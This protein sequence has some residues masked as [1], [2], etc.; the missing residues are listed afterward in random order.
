MNDDQMTTSTGD[1]KFQTVLEKNTFHY[2]N[3][4]F[5]NKF[6]T[7][8]EKKI[9][10]IIELQEK[11]KEDVCIK[12]LIDDFLKKDNG[13]DLLLAINGIS[14]ETLLRIVTIIRV[15]NDENINKFFNKNKWSTGDYDKE[16]PSSK[17]KKLIKTNKYFRED[18]VKFFLEVYNEP[19]REKILPKFEFEKL[20]PSKISNI[21]TLTRDTIDTLIRSKVKGNYSAQFENNAEKLIK[22]ILEELN[23]PYQKGDLPLLSEHDSTRKRTMDF[24]IPNKKNPKIVIESSYVQTTSSGLGDKAKTE[25]GVKDLLEKHYPEVKFIGFIDGTGWISRKKDAVRLCEAFKNVYTFHPDEL[26]K[27]KKCLAEICSEYF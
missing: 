14:F 20:N 12:T 15:I 17:V 22:D 8:I 1:L 4:E 16:W 7:S 2:S 21:T 5:E 11:I 19:F 3:P 6:Q 13:I 24:I 25:N 23:I 18:I 9:E 10:E 27:F 26:E